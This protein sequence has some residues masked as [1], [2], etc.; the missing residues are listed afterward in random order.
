[1]VK[2]AA[3]RSSRICCEFSSR[4]DVDDEDDVTAK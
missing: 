3:W 2:T 4:D 1:L